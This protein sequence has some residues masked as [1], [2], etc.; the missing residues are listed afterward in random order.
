MLMKKSIII[1]WMPLF[2]GVLLGTFSV[3]MGKIPKE[4][5]VWTGMTVIGNHVGYLL[6][7]LITAYFNSQKWLKS[8]LSSSLTIIIATLVYYFLIFVI[9][10]Y[11]NSNAAYGFEDGLIYWPVT[12]VICGIF[13][14]AFVWL[15]KRTKSKIL[16]LS[17][18]TVGYFSMLAVI[19]LR[20]ARFYII[21]YFTDPELISRQ[22]AGLPGA[23]FEVAFAVIIT[24]AVWCGAMKK[25][26]KEHP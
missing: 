13:S 15:L 11:N 14:A 26:Y 5:A 24:T 3:V 4:I 7:A 18:F 1:K 22:A 21:L 20:I 9:Q 10:L 23:I 17:F 6:G 8:F 25:T 2:T 12:G 16:F 19:Y